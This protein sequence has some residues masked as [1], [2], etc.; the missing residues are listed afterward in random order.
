MPIIII[1]NVLGFS[2]KLI[3]SNYKFLIV[4]EFAL[5]WVAF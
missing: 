2:I 3:I 1:K 5:T 4:T